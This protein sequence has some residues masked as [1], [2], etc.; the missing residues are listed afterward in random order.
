MDSN[1]ISSIEDDSVISF[2]LGLEEEQKK[3]AWF[4]QLA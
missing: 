1:P 3:L 2:D 4:R